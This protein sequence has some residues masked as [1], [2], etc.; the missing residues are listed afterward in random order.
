MPILDI[1]V[2]GRDSPNR[3]YT[4]ALADA[5][6]NVFNSAS[7]HTWVKVRH[8]PE[9]QYAENQIGTPA[10]KP[11]FVS[12]LLRV[13]PDAAELAKLADALAVAIGNASGCPKENVHIVFQPEAAGRVAFGGQLVK[14]SP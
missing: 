3:S 1:E 5:V 4:Q 10:P 7:G 13:L 11:I 9:A 14:H 12:V 8:I 2:V 6:G